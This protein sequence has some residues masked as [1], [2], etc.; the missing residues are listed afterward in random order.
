MQVAE[1]EQRLGLALVRRAAIPGQRLGM[2]LPPAMGMW[3][4][5]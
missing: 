5:V 1:L 4:I 3:E 2:V